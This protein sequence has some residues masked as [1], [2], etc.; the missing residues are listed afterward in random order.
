MLA[1]AIWS[2]GEDEMFERILVVPCGLI[3]AELVETVRTELAGAFDL[4]VEV[5]APLLDPVFAY[6][7]NR[8]QFSAEAIIRKLPLS[9]SALV[10]G[11]VDHDVYVPGVASLFGLADPERNCALVAL[12]SLAPREIRHTESV[13][14]HRPSRHTMRRAAREA[15]Y[16]LQYAAA[17]RYVPTRHPETREH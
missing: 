9:E 14:P 17:G 16:Q 1:R 6:N 13:G 15:V 3:D 4:P 11:I 7:P 12:P 5:P 10:L 2:R 8:G